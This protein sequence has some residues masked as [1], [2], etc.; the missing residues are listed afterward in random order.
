M[1]LF[2]EDQIIKFATKY[3]TDF[4]NDYASPLI[5]SK[6]PSLTKSDEPNITYWLICQEILMLHTV[7]ISKHKDYWIA[8]IIANLTWN[9]GRLD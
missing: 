1:N 2:T 8:K 3:T 6:N 9:N 5:S 4:Y 7:I